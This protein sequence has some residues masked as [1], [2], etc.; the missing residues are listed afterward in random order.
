MN[1][2]YVYVSSNTGVLADS[3][4][5]KENN[6][7]VKEP[8]QVIANKQQTRRIKAKTTQLVTRCFLKHKEGSCT[9]QEWN[10]FMMV[11]KSIEDFNLKNYN[12]IHAPIDKFKLKYVMAYKL[13]LIEDKKYE[14]S[15]AKKML[16]IA[17]RMFEYAIMNDVINCTNYFKAVKIE[18]KSKPLKFLSSEEVM[19]IVKLD[20]NKSPY[21]SFCRD[22]FIFQCYTGLAYC[23]LFTLKF[24]DIKKIDHSSNYWILKERTKTGIMSQIPLLP[25]AVSIILKYTDSESIDLE[26][27]TTIFKYYSNQK[28]NK[29]L[30]LIGKKCGLNFSLTTHIG[31]KTFAMNLL[32]SDGV[33]IESVSSILGHANTIITQSTYAK[34]L[35]QKLFKETA[36]LNLYNS[37]EQKGQ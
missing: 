11:K 22:L 2:S 19:R 4:E 12:K 23:D 37:D 6:T 26:S 16:Q 31:R 32:N 21:Q 28:F 20:L 10:R 15:T 14:L 13:F 25:G 7:T 24:N 30:K 18:L 1:Y 29:S 36:N 5:K 35:P 3:T 33:S 8:K 17:T 9:Y 27:N 34:V